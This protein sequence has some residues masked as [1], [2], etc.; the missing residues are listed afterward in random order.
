MRAA[1]AFASTEQRSM[2][3]Y[4][5]I[6]RQVA[7]DNDDNDMTSECLILAGVSLATT[8]IAS[9]TDLSLVCVPGAMIAA[10]VALLKS[11]QEK[12]DWTEKAANSIG[13][14]AVGSTVPSAFMHYFWPE[15]AGKFMWQAWAFLGFMFGLLGWPLAY[16]FVKV[17]GLRSEKFANR[18]VRSIEKRFVGDDESKG[19][20]GEKQDDR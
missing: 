3:P 4:H 12:R 8:F 10:L 6:P 11:T 19:G 13:I 14:S 1:I 2:T 16:A 7:A 20:R 5:P 15:I 18:T 17:C 9:Q